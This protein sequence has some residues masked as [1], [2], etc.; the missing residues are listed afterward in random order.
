MALAPSSLACWIMISNAS[1]RVRSHRLLNREMFPP[2]I[3]CSPAPMV[4]NRERERTTM[5]RTTP[6]LR[7]IRAPGR[8]NAVV[9][10]SWDTMLVSDPPVDFDYRLFVFHN[11][12]QEIVADAVARG[13]VD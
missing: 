5:P 8:S 12:L 13:A 3:V 4:P 9:T 7:A 1:W 2:T 11:G 10:F 6:R